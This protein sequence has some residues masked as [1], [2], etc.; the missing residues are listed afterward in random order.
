MATKKNPAQIAV[1]LLQDANLSLE[2]RALLFTAVLGKLA[3]L[4]LRDIIISDPNTGFL[5]L[6]GKEVDL[7][8]GRLLREGARAVLNNFA[9]KT[10]HEQV[11]YAA[12]L[13]GFI[14]SSS[15]GQSLTGKAAIWW[16]DQEI[17]ILKMLAG[18]TTGEADK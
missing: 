2:D 16:G 3:L 14:K 9:F 8:T 5:L 11:R 10:I 1:A 4:P 18:V 17:E 12:I 6:N 15:E 13:S 7:E